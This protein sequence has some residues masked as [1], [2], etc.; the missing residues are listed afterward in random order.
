MLWEY[1]TAWA[2]LRIGGLLLSHN[3]DSNDAFSDFCQSVKYRGY[4]LGNLGG[5]VKV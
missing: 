2:H 3:I 4:V 5:V 1:Q